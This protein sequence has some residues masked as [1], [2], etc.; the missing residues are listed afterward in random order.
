MVPGQ[1]ALEHLS[2]VAAQMEA[3]GDLY[4]VRYSLADAIGVGTGAVAADNLDL[5]LLAQPTRKGGSGAIGQEINRSA[6]LHVDEHGPIG[7]TTA[8][9]EVV[10]T[11]H[12]WRRGNWV[13]R[14]V[15]QAEER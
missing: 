6:C 15:H 8:A 7:L 5:R 4:G 13:G 12:P 3:I 14:G 11:Q 2:R 1:H 10:Y 9:G